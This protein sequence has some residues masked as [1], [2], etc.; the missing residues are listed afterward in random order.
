MHKATHKKPMKASYKEP[1][2]PKKPHSNHDKGKPL[3]NN[4]SGKK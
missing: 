1:I 3:S 2:K 4:K